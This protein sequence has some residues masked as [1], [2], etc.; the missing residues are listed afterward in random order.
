MLGFHHRDLKFTT[1]KCQ[2]TYILEAPEFP[3]LWQPL[4]L[5]HEPWDLPT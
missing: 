2:M 3:A 5:G 1:Y 4:S